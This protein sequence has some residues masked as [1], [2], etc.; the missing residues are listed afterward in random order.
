MTTPTNPLREAIDAVRRYFQLD[1]T[2]NAR[3]LC[4]ETE[5]VLVE[6]TEAE[7]ERDRWKREYHKLYDQWTAL[8]AQYADLEKERD[9]L[10]ELVRRAADVMDDIWRDAHDAYYSMQQWLADAKK[11]LGE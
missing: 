10:R 4:D 7:A 2:G 8:G 11:E 9:R 3:R 1:P 6:H 5:K